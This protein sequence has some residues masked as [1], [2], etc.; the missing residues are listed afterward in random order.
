[1]EFVRSRFGAVSRALGAGALAVAAIALA[2]CSTKGG[3]V[4]YNVTNFGAPDAPT[5]SGVT[6]AY[7]IGPQDVLSVTVFRVP[8][9]SGDFE[10]DGNGNLLMPLLG[11][12]PVNGKTNMEAQTEIAQQLGAK[13]LQNPEVQVS[14]KSS[15][16]QKV[17]IDGAVKNAG[18]YSIGG[19][20]TTL[21]QAL[22]LSGSGTTD[23]NMRRV[24]VFRMI[25]GQRN[26]AAFDAEDIRRGKAPDPVIYGNDLIVVADN[27]G[28][29]TFQTILQSVPMIAI[30]HPF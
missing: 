20:T 26:A 8:N 21:M 18:I 27:K 22:A 11:P 30:F 25:N 29:A 10:V 23:A 9:L 7:R 24:V 1:M 13:Y 19:G 2:G 16:R 3:P 6:N 28:K 14:V 15:P 4:P 12:V 5:I 17:T